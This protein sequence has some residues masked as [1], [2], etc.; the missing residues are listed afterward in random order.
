MFV[1]HSRDKLINAI[2]YFVEN[3]DRCHTLKL[4]KLLNFLDFEHFRQTGR[5][6]TGLQYKAWPNGPAPSELWHELTTVPRADLASAVSIY[7]VRDDVTDEVLRRAMKPKKKFN[8]GNFTRR[9]LEIMEKLA[10]IFKEADASDM[11]GIS[12]AR[13]MPW[14]KVYRGGAG[15]WKQIPYEL[16]FTSRPVLEDMP[17]I[18]QAEFEYRKQAFKEID[19]RS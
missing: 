17:S 18:D 3:T 4:F 16:T 6:V 15:E 12:H 8:P 5:S 9:E 14:G 10:F 11:T 13:D 2:L 19:S 1:D 7:P